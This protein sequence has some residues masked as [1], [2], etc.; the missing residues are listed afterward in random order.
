MFSKIKSKVARVAVVTMSCLVMSQ[1]M[2]QC[3]P[4]PLPKVSEVPNNATAIDTAGHRASNA[5]R[6]AFDAP[7]NGAPTKW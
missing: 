2:V 6:D 5:R 7:A 4:K 1:A 3:T